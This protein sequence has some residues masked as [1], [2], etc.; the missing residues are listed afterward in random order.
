MGFLRAKPLKTRGDVLKTLFFAN[1]LFIS[2]SVLK[3]ENIEC[4]LLDIDNTIKP[5][6]AE[7][8]EH[9]YREWI[10]NVKAQGIKVILCSNNYVRNVQPIAEQ[11]SCEYVAFCL[12]PSPF[13][14]FRAYLKSQTQRKK[15]VVIGDQFFTDILGGKFMQMKTI[16]VDPISYESEGKTVRL[17]RKMTA[18]FTNIIKKRQNPYNER[19]NTND[20]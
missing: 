11:V 1:L 10:D 8:I 13:G 15:I 19:R 12:K 17:R 9:C 18:V 20:E 3:K 5:Y 2:P 14:Y 6:G 16:L 4:V 7:T